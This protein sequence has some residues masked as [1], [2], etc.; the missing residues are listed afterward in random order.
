MKFELPGLPYASD[1]LEPAISKS[2]IGYHYGKHHQAYVNN[3]NS[4]I[5]G[6][7]FENM[8]LEEIIRKSEGGIF[9]NAAQVYNHTFY[10]SSLRPGGGGLPEGALKEA[11]DKKWG[12]FEQFQKEFNNAASTLFGSGWAWLVK[13]EKGDLSI[14]KESNAGC[15][16][17]SGLVPILAFDVW[18]HAYYLDYQN[19]RADYLAALWGVIDWK[20]V[21]DRY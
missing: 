14:L 3:L 15:P 5:P 6:T 19:R 10:F 13:N 2:T 7:Q 8:E 17:T 1:A 18:E 9:N 12:P 11:I 16:L 4:L 21:S 20:T